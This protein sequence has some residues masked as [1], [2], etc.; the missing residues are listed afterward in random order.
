LLPGATPRRILSKDQALAQCANH[1]RA[2][3]PDASVEPMPSTSGAMQLIVSQGLKDAAAI[4]SAA[5]LESYGLHVVARNIGNVKNNKTRFAILSPQNVPDG[6]P[7]G[8]DTTALVVYPHHDRV[9]LLQQILTVISQHHG[10]SCSSIHSRPDTHG[11]FR[12]YLELEAHLRDPRMVACLRDLIRE[13]EAADSEVR[14]FGTYPRR[15]FTEPKVRRIGIIGG[16]GAMGQWLARFLEG[17]GYEVAVSGRH[18]PLT[19]AAC[20]AASDVVI[21]NVPIAHTETVIET[22]GPMLRPGQ[23]LVDNTSIKGAPVAAMTRVAPGGV[24]VLGMHTVF[25]PATT[26][27]RRQNVVFT[28]T[29]SSGELAAEF[30]AIFHKHGARITHT[31]PAHHDQQMAFHQ[32]LEHLTKVALAEVLCRYFPNGDADRYA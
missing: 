6:A 14:V 15:I 27:L 9:G 18:T 22:V 5:A 25:G 7:S 21:V 11:A 3:H 24:E 28:R 2:H 4:G 17:A 12:F 13:M 26:E 19:Y 10:L 32:N 1:L 8:R 30:E 29:D 31:T 23:L 16:T 20:V